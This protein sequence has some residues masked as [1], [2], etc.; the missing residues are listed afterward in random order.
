MRKKAFVIILAATWLALSASQSF[1]DK[2]FLRE[3]AGKEEITLADGCR[4]IYC[5]VGGDENEKNIDTILADLLERKCIKKNYQGKAERKLTRGQFAY[6]LC[7]ALD[8]RGGLTMMVIGTTERYALRECI[9]RE[10]M[11]DVNQG[12]YVTGLELLG[13]LSRAEKYREEKGK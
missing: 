13:V 8:I 1:A 7:R 5:F 11:P 12:K 9:F 3:M 2:Q 4:A 6:M 10:L